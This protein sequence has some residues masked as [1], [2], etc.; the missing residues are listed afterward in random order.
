M[1]PQK[2]RWHLQAT[3]DRGTSRT[4][5]W[6][7]PGKASALHQFLCPH[8]PVPS[9]ALGPGES[10]RLG[11]GP[12]SARRS[13]ALQ[14]RSRGPGPCHGGPPG[15]RQQSPGCGEALAQT[16]PGDRRAGPRS[17]RGGRHVA[18]SG[19]D[20]R[21]PSHRGGARRRRHPLPTP[22]FDP[23]P[24][25]YLGSPRP[26]RSPQREREGAGRPGAPPGGRE[27]ALHPRAAGGA[28]REKP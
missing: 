18:C 24:P 17:R 5:D 13:G 16:G 10:H 7:T 26:P 19:R 1:S 11:A 23:R 4:R 9:P 21:G 27:D 28:G 12:S 8:Q 25:P 2:S 22:N 3:Q 14:H 6:G 15:L 20:P